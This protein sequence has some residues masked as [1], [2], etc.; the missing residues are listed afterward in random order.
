MHLAGISNY[1][2]AQTA[3]ITSS[4]LNTQISGPISVDGQ[5]Q[6][7]ITGGM[8]PGGGANLFHSF[9]EFSVPIDA[10][11]NFRND[12][13]LPTSY[14]LGRVT[15]G[16]ISNIFGAIHTSNFD[17]AN[18]FL[19]N[20]AGFLFG[21]HATL[22]VGGM[23]SFTSADYL[24]LEDG[25]RF[26]AVSSTAADALLTASPV[27][28]FG[29]LDSTSGAI[30]VQGSHL[31]A[32]PGKG[33]ALVGGN[34][35]VE[36]GP[37]ADGTRQQA[38]L[39]A[40]NGTI[41][42]AI[43]A[44]PGEFEAMSLQ[45][46]ESEEGNSFTSFGSVMLN[47]GS[48]VNL[49]GTDTVSIRGGQF[50]LSVN[51]ASLSTAESAG[52]TGAIV[53]NSGSSIN[54]EASGTEL[55]GTISLKAAK[56]IAL[57]G[58]S[59]ITTSVEDGSGELLTLTAP[60]IELLEE[61]NIGTSTSGLGKAGNVELQGDQVTFTSRSFITTRTQAGGRGGDITIRGLT[62]Q[63]SSA[64]DIR[65]SEN[66]RLVSETKGDGEGEQGDAGHIRVE[67][68]RLNLSGG[69]F[70]NTTSRGSTGKG[71]NILVHATESVIISG[72]G[73]QLTSESTESSSGNAGNVSITAPSITV[74]NGGSILSNTDFKGNA[75]TITVDT[76][77]LQLL[78]GGRITSSSLPGTSFSAKG[79][80]VTVRGIANSAQSIFIDGSGSGIFTDTQ[81]EGAG[82]NITL[83]AENITIQHG[84]TLSAKTSGTEPSAIGGTITVNAD[85]VRLQSGA[86]ITANS[87][88]KADAGDIKITTTDGLTMQNSSIT[89]K[90][91]SNGSETSARGGN[92]KVT[93]SPE[94][95]V[96]LQDN[97][98]ISASVPGKGDGGNVTID[99][100]FVVLQN[101]KV[102]AQADEGTGGKITIIT[103]MFQKDAG[104]VVNADAARGVNGTVTIQAPYAPGSGKIQSLGNRPLQA[105]S[106]L[107]Q[108]CA[109]MAGGQFSSFTVAG[110]NSLPTEPGGWISSPLALALL[111]SHSDTAD[112]MGLQANLDKPHGERSLLSLRQIAP[113][114]FLTKAFAGASSAGCAS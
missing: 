47:R 86:T 82:G 88:G 18:L 17:G 109:A 52:G 23:V 25:A 113:P 11:A 27:A 12:A 40:P 96:Y 91:H 79:G 70:F 31:E 67:T 72:S 55:G 51:D 8:R 95:T 10:I 101:S 102:L 42:L 15:G 84:G 106:L 76:N 26:N 78:S 57:Y 60:S 59:S 105:T 80:A 66:S 29:F 36:S 75:G 93:T 100:K 87:N 16:N 77:N 89:T 90:V 43:A 110:R 94:A 71:G 46:V 35:T 22:N 107:N 2:S 4:G 53:L 92:I 114:G 21:P 38:H 45:S 81:G 73:T 104:S 50:V 83:K 62:G 30:R 33:I 74:E 13:N 103:S 5:V 85:Q 9:G 3:P 63:G 56:T 68:A 37:L 28:A 20:P 34:I 6:Y 32:K 108:S 7:D 1:A 61:S 112:N 111:H 65:L 24:K 48:T 44:S 58:N 98:E 19:M 99:P 49:S 14:I 54:T 97:S 69:S 39:S 64:R 41:Q